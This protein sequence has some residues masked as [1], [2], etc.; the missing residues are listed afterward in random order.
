MKRSTALRVTIIILSI[1]IIVLVS[2]VVVKKPKCICIVPTHRV[3]VPIESVSK[4]LTKGWYKWTWSQGAAAPP[5][6]SIVVSFS[7]WADVESA[8]DQS[9][10]MDGTTTF[11]SLGGGNV[12]GKFTRDTLTVAADSNHLHMIRGK[13]FAG[14]CFDAEVGDPGL[15][16]YFDAA[17]TAC[18]R[19]GLQVMVTTSHSAPYGIPDA[20][21]LVEGWVKNPNI[22]ILSPQLYTQ[23]TEVKP[24][25]QTSMDVDWSTYK[26]AVPTFSPSIVSVDQY[27]QVQSYFSMEGITCAGYFVWGQG[28]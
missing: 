26:N 27:S 15:A 10:P 13:G 19:A 16:Q 11:L 24:D 8:L 6:T 20:R 25:F 9:S 18:K 7:G 4:P 22:D 17:F 14:V 23:G 12:H 28:L 5:D 1:V 21:I 3:S 2:I